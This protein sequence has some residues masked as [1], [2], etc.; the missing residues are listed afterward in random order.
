MVYL[1][2]KELKCSHSTDNEEK[3]DLISDNKQTTGSL[4]TSGKVVRECRSVSLQNSVSFLS[5]RDQTELFKNIARSGIAVERQQC[6]CPELR[7]YRATD[8]V[9]N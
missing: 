8:K 9:Q 7:L 2:V 6:A 1:G 4:G 5:K 3:N